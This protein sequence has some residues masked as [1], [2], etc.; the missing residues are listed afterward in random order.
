M[1]VYDIRCS[2]QALRGISGLADTKLWLTSSGSMGVNALYASLFESRITRLDLHGL[3]ASHM[4]GP[5]YFNVLRFLDI[6]TAVAMAMERS[7]V[8]LYAKEKAPWE[9]VAKTAEKL[10]VTQNFQIREPVE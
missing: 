8:V 3:P 10:G 7:K 4:T 2:L 5:T 9:P 1:Q 6:P